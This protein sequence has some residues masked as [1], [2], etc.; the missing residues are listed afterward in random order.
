MRISKLL[1]TALILGL[2]VIGAADA[3]QKGSRG[4]F[5]NNRA[6][7]EAAASAVGGK[8]AGTKTTTATSADRNSSGAFSASGAFNERAGALGIGK[9]NAYGK[10]T[11]A[12][13]GTTADVAG[14]DSAATSVS[15][16]SSRSW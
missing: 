12:Y 6:A 1:A 2:G 13:S 3:G 8:V 7:A 14:R 16:S 10:A 4:G 9:A 11:D 15:G 5:S